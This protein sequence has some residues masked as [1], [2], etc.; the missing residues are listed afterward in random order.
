VHRSLDTL[1]R[2]APLFP[3]GT[4]VFVVSDFLTP[5]PART[6]VRFRSLRWDVTPVIVQDPVWEQSFPDVGGVVLPVADPATGAVDDVWVAPRTARARRAENEARLR[7]LREGFG[8]LGFDPV[9]VE[10]AGPLDVEA[11][12]HAWAERRRRLRRTRV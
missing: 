10:S 5:V 7:S 4:F 6:W 1:F 11:C 9:L 8:R 12:F 2:H 3:V